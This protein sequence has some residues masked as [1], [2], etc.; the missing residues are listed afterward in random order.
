M[1]IT[2]EVISDVLPLYLS[3][4]ASADTRAL[5]E[6]YFR[7]DPEFEVLARQSQTQLDTLGVSSPTDRQEKEALMRVNRILRWRSIL[8]GVALFFSLMPF[9]MAGNSDQ[10]LT[11]ILLRD[12]PQLAVVFGVAA[13]LV[14][15]GYYWT[16]RALPDA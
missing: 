3:G 14:W 11:W 10:G 15:G 12:M 9:S 5:V 1:K 13:V 6:A 8:L 7:Q 2:R 16:F 4:E